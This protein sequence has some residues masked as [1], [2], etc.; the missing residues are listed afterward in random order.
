MSLK[1]KRLAIQRVCGS[2][3]FTRLM[4]TL[5]I[6]VGG[7]LWV[8]AMMIR[9]MKGGRSIHAKAT[10]ECGRSDDRRP[11][12]ALIRRQLTCRRRALRGGARCV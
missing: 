2:A 12:P 8:T 1:S 3:V 5:T 4:F 10:R 6:F 11:E 9:Y 7:G